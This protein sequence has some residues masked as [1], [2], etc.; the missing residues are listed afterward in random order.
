MKMIMMTMMKTNLDEDCNESNED[1]NWYLEGVVSMM[2][3]TWYEDDIE[4]E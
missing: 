4:D 3:L 1:C 2:E